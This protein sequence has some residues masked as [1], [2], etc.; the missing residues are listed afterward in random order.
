M[1][2]P[3]ALYIYKVYISI[4]KVYISIYKLYISIY[5]AY[6]ISIY[7]LTIRYELYL[8]KLKKLKLIIKLT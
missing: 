2:D 6:Y 5:K 3:F 8:L 4:N 1:H 7:K